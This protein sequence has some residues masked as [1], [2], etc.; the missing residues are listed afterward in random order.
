MCQNCQK[1]PVTTLT[2]GRP[3][4][5]N[6]FLKYFEKKVRKTIRV[7]KLI[8][9]TDSLVIALSGGKDS[10]TV[11]DLLSN[12]YTHS[13]S[14][15]LTAVAIDEGIDGYRDKTL[16]YA[17]D[18]CHK[19]QIPLEVVSYK[20]AFGF[21]LDNVVKGRRAC[22]VCGVLR[23]SL[24]NRKARE[25][26]A[27]KLVTG[28]NLDDEA[29]TILMNQFRRNVE[30]SARLGPITGVDTHKGFV[31]RI[32]PL[33]F[34]SEKEVMTYAYLK[35][36][37]REFNECPYNRGSY[38]NQVRDLLN[39]FEEKFPGTKYSIV[40]S[41]LEVLPLLKQKEKNRFRINA[42]SRCNEPCSQTVCQKCMVLE[43]I[44]ST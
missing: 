15:S 35:G 19:R 6:C 40:N 20:E 17:R 33:Y 23:R 32:K 13:P 10:L 30:T 34:M 42:C 8:G 12:I 7:Y 14:V 16:E 9:K 41:F 26:G 21:K 27:N 43:E 38:R 11:L 29:Q 1:H 39:T 25:L 22:S 28:H 5:K 24:L 31:R 18:F 3:L 36:L 4:C 37:T 2:S 44:K